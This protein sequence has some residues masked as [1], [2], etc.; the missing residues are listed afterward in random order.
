MG[1]RPFVCVRRRHAHVDDDNIRGAVLRPRPR[2]RQRSARPPPSSPYSA[3]IRPSPCAPRNSTESSTIVTRTSSGPAPGGL[4]GQITARTRS[5]RPARPRQHSTTAAPPTPSSVTSTVIEGRCAQP[6]PHGAGTAVLRHVGAPRPR[7]SR[8]DRARWA[9]ENVPTGRPRG[10]PAP[11]SGRRARSSRPRSARAAGWMPAPAP[12]VARLAWSWA[13]PSQAPGG[14]AS[15]R[16]VPNLGSLARPRSVEGHATRRC[17]L[18]PCRSRSIRRALRPST[19][20]TE[21]PDA[22][23]PCAGVQRAR[24]GPEQARD[25]QPVDGGHGPHDVRRGYEEHRAQQPVRGR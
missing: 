23:P 24:L 12:V 20:S 14:A 6:H 10:S 3:R 4:A 16:P 17:W 21:I 2:G 15:P 9:L 7:R 18:R 1:A 25:Q 19:A 8:R 5:T 11:G 13:W 22:P